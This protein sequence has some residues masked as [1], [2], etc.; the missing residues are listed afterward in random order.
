MD[1]FAMVKNA[2]LPDFCSRTFHPKTW[3]VE[4]SVVYW[5]GLYAY[6]FLSILNPVCFCDVGWDLQL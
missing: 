4:A 3:V 1:L 2:K 6:V 5:D